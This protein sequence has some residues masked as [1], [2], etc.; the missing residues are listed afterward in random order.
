MITEC[1]VSV[2][3]S[4]MKFG[5]II[6]LFVACLYVLVILAPSAAAQCSCGQRV[7]GTRRICQI[8]TWLGCLWW[9]TITTCANCA[10]GTWSSSWNNACSNCGAGRYNPSWRRCNSCVACQRG[11]FTGSAVARVCSVCPQGRYASAS[12]AARTCWNCPA[13]RYGYTTGVWLVNQCWSCGSGQFSRAGARGCSNCGFGRCVHK[14]PIEGR[15]FLV[16]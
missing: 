5:N 12:I 8:N 6:V 1:V 16:F 14:N 11:R 3:V 9:R 15:C 7:A 2:F 10:P 4:Q 13:G